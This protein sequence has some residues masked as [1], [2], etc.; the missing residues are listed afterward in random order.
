MQRIFSNIFD[1]KRLQPGTLLEYLQ[2]ESLVTHDCSTLGGNSGSCVIDLAT[3]QVLGL[4]FSGRY[5]EANRAV[6]LWD[7]REDP[8]LARAGVNFV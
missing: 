7:L 6:A 5:G 3:R 2:S 1:V 8:L 4:H